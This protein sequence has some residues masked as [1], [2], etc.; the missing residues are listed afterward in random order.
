VGQSPTDNEALAETAD[1]SAVQGRIPLHKVAL[2]RDLPGEALTQIEAHGQERQYGAGDLVCDGG[3]NHGVFAILAGRVE[4]TSPGK[5]ADGGLLLAEVGAGGCVGEFIAIDGACSSA[6]VRAAVPTVAVE[7]TQAAFRQLIERYPEVLL[8][9]AA[10]LIAIIRSLNVRLE[11]L[12]NFDNE[13]RLIHRKLLL[14][15]L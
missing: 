13:V 6:F 7:I 14:I 4:V 12:G 9:L 8:R 3:L 1:G 2:F 5:A 10:H 15:T 11:E